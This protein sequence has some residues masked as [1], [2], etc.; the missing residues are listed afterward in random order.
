MNTKKAR[1]RAWKF[2]E[3]ALTLAAAGSAWAL[4]KGAGCSGCD[5]ASLVFPGKNLAAMGLLYYSALL[6]LAIGAGPSIVLYAGVLVATGVHAGLVAVL[7]RLGVVCAPCLF[8]AGAA[9]GALVSA[10][11]CDPANAF[12]ASVVSPGA[13]FVVQA[14]VLL[15]GALPA[16]AETKA[17][18]ERV[19]S[20]ELSSAAPLRGK[21]RMVA[22]TRP[23]CGYC[24]ELER[25][26]LPKL[27]SEL[28]DRLEVER[29]RA[30]DL[31][32]I[33]TPT[34]ILSGPAGRRLF[35]G[36]PPT[37]DLR[38]AIESL[39]G[40]SHGHETVLEKSR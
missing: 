4:F 32:G 16:A 29:R 3:A 25:D 15:S 30:E 6:A 28:G 5:A 23:D 33:P 37:E 38:L 27:R 22:Y 13:A 24:I 34:I 31:P 14:W 39:M 12:R 20:S 21:V 17:Q 9:L 36:L 19:V 1:P 2:L 8:T 7:V 40:D 18:A 35:P 26:V 10:I 11:A